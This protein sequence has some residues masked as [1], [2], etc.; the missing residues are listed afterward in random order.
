MRT[1]TCSAWD[2][3]DVWD[4]GTAPLSGCMAA[5]QWCL[6][7]GRARGG[8]GSHP[9]DGGGRGRSDEDQVAQGTDQVLQSTCLAVVESVSSGTDEREI[10]NQDLCRFSAA[11]LPNRPKNPRKRP[12]THHQR[13][14]SH[15]LTL[16]PEDHSTVSGKER[17]KFRERSWLITGSELHQLEV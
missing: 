6:R 15:T 9:K 3:G 13:Q 10:E 2:V 12:N 11:V 7:V 17:R 4:L 8:H 16:A 14:A 1:K 5:A